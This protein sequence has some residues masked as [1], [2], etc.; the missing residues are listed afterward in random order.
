MLQKR[1]TFNGKYV[2]RML[3]KKGV[4]ASNF[5]NIDKMLFHMKREIKPGDVI[6][7]MSCRGFDG[8][9]KQIWDI[10]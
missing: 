8:L 4:L 5:N 9:Y 1:E 7:I 3:V 6:C 2:S 10:L